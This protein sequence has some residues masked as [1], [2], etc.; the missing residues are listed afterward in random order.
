MRYSRTLPLSFIFLSM[1]F[2][3]NHSNASAPIGSVS[4]DV[5]NNIELRG[6]VVN[7]GSAIGGFQGG[8]LE[9]ETSIGTVHGEYKVGGDVNNNILLYGLLGGI[10]VVNAAVTWQGNLCSKVAIGSV[11]ASTCTYASEAK[12]GHAL[13]SGK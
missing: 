1:S 11:G 8:G 3:V 5:N 12:T 10:S 2:F 6:G 9:M 4:G 7:A 13:F